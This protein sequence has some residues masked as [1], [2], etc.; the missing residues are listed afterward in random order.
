[1]LKES[2]YLLDNCLDKA[3]KIGRNEYIK[4]NGNFSLYDEFKKDFLN[5][6]LY[7]GMSDGDIQEKEIKFINSNLGYQFTK[8]IIDGYAKNAMVG[9]DEFLKT[10]PVSLRY[11]VRNNVGTEAVIGLNSYNLIK[12]YCSTFH[13]VGREFIACNNMVSPEEIDALTKYTIMLE[14][15]VDNILDEDK[16]PPKAIPYSPQ[17][18][19]GSMDEDNKD[20][21]KFVGTITEPDEKDTIDSLFAELVSL[22]GLDSVKQEVGNLVNLL[23]VCKM[24]EDRGLSVPPVSM[25]LVFT[26]NPGTGKTTVARILA[27][28]YHAMGILSKGQLVEV[29]RSG[30]VA[31]YMGQTAIKC[32][33]AID[34][35]LGGVLFIDEAY[36]LSFNKGEG[37]FG[38]EAIDTINKAMEDHRDDLIV[39]VAGYHNEMDTFLDANPGLR[40]RFNKYIEFPD[41]KAEELL[42]ILESKATA[43]DYR[44]SEEAKQYA[45]DR[46]LERINDKSASFGNARAVRNYLDKAISN[47]ANRLIVSGAVEEEALM[48]ITI[49]DIKDISL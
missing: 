24:R 2:R 37:D 41:Y 13:N 23:K 34:K 19:Q 20:E 22:I 35:A 48:S 3:N 14:Q 11:F 33:E 38:Q 4:T 39:I 15:H 12:L 7:L 17:G 10:P 1:M 8:P 40:S 45:V 30:L 43:I 31:G 28:I 44:L 32:Q 5:F 16:V 36:S 18:R 29:D 25:H 27:K 21:I 46:F 49:D 6:L 47:Q 26:G 42:Q 9:S